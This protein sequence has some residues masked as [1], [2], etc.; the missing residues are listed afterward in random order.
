MS[1]VMVS[2][3]LPGVLVLCLES[4]LTRLALVKVVWLLFAGYVVADEPS[5]SVTA[6]IAY[7][8]TM[9]SFRAELSLNGQRQNHYRHV[10]K[11]CSVNF[12]FFSRNFRRLCPL[13]LRSNMDVSITLDY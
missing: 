9:A 4:A 1:W 13:S 3:E 5:K 6:V 12:W 7:V 11:N 10:G 8:D 2:G